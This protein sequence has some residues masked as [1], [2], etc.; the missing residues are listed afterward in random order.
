MR[1]A[2]HPSPGDHR[3]V[4]MVVFPGMGHV[5]NNMLQARAI[6]EQN[7]EWFGHWLLDKP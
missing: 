6:Q 7:L 3:P 2:S 5:P 1:S 4:R